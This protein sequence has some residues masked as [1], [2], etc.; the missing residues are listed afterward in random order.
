MG[1]QIVNSLYLLD[2]AKISKQKLDIFIKQ[3]ILKKAK[4]ILTTEKDAVKLDP[5]IKR[6]LQVIYLETHLKITHN[7]CHLV[8]LV[9]KILS[10][11][12]KSNEFKN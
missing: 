6:D 4:F 5:N 1:F 10:N 8:A 9:E 12:V 3:S 2:H 11:D 7:E